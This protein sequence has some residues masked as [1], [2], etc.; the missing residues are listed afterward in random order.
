M[1]THSMID[2]STLPLKLCRPLISFFIDNYKTVIQ[3]L[4][5][6]VE[7]VYWYLFDEHIQSGCCITTSN[8]LS[9]LLDE[10]NN[11][12]FTIDEMYEEAHQYV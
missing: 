1:F 4:D 2:S 9:S 10:F 12:T 11:R 6:I 3:R 7:S 5:D 8:N